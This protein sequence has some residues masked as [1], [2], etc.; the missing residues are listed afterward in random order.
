MLDVTTRT[1]NSEKNKFPIFELIKVI[2]TSQF[3]K[4]VEI[5]ESVIVFC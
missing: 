2:W 5:I 1:A 3:I 4:N